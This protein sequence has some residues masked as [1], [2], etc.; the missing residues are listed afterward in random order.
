MTPDYVISS[1][2]HPPWKG[3]FTSWTVTVILKYQMRQAKWETVFKYC[4][5]FHLLDVYSFKPLVS[6]YQR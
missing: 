4:D 1:L 6:S 2:D 3:T 5:F